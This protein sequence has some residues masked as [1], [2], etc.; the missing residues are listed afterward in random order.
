M[1]DMNDRERLIELLLDF[2]GEFNSFVFDR[3]RLAD[4]L[5]AHDVII[6][7]HGRWDGGELGDCTYCGHEGCASDI[8]NGGEIMYCPHCGARLD[9]DT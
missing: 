3:E 4:Y 6:Q 2:E 5:I 8:W 9:A 7:K 1:N